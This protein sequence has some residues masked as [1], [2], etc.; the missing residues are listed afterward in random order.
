GT[1]THCQLTTSVT[2]PTKSE[3]K[4]FVFPNPFSFS[5]TLT[6]NDIFKN[7]ILTVYN[8]F[9]Q[10]VK[11]IKNISGQTFTLYRDN[12]PSGLYY[13]RLIRNNKLIMTDKLIITD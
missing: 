2:E 13:I 6:T 4:L 10:Q 7:A 12:F 9:G 1:T 5:T 11:Q 8:S 3:N